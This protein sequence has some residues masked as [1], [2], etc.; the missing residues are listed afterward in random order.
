[1]DINLINNTET[2]E[3]LA[4]EYNG[5]TSIP[6]PEDTKNTNNIVTS[7]NKNAT[8]TTNT[9]IN[10]TGDDPTTLIDW[11]RKCIIQNK[12]IERLN[13]LNQFLELE[14]KLGQ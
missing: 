2:I 10:N 9:T 3:P 6:H 7:N 5:S 13:K 1:M 11:Q 14:R 12:E 4:K 8:T